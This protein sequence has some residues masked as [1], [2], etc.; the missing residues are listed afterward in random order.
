M[1]EHRTTP[2][3]IAA[4][5]ANTTREGISW[6][7]DIFARCN[8]NL[9]AELPQAEALT[10]A[11][12]YLQALH[13]AAETGDV[14]L[15]ETLWRRILVT[16]HLLQRFGAAAVARIC[17]PLACYTHFRTTVGMPPDAFAAEYEAAVSALNTAARPL[18]DPDLID[19]IRWIAGIHRAA[20]LLDGLA[21]FL[22]DPELQLEIASWTAVTRR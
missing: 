15:T 9:M 6:W 10:W 3:D 2:A 4:Q 8:A 20:G 12:V 16:V 18:S 19:R 7:L 5:L 1:T 14:P 13:Q 11:A 22:P 17:S 21:A